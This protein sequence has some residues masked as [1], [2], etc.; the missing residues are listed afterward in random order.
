M[1]AEPTDRAVGLLPWDAIDTV[2]V[3]MDGTVL[4]LAFDNFFWLELVPS[5]YAALA[6]LSEADARRIVAERSRRLNGSLAWYCLDHWST[7]LGLDIAGLKRSHRHLIRYLPQAPE[8][9]GAVRRRGKALRIVTNAHRA[10][11]EVK[12]EQTG[13]DALVDGLISSHD[14]R[15][16]KESHD[17]WV[18]LQRLC[19]FDPERTAL[20]EDSRPVLEAAAGYGIR[21]TVAVG[22]PDSRRP[23]RSIDGFA[24]VEGVAEL[25]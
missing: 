12:V 25:L 17:F 21:F 8:F 13:L 2:L 23:A 24:T 4:D 6:G 16:A 18:H 19:P 1:R 7:E 14:F 10:A 15:V 9:L 5:H 22:R 3:D 20:I 11:L